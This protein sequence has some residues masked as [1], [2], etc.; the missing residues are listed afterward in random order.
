M[1]V[2]VVEMRNQTVVWHK[3]AHR[4]GDLVSKRG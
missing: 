3:G 1:M 2:A 4:L